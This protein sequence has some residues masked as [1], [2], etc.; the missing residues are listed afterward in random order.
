MDKIMASLNLKFW[1]TLE[2]T[3]ADFSGLTVTPEA[4]DLYGNPSNGSGNGNG[5]G[6]PDG[7]QEAPPVGYEY[8]PPL[9]GQ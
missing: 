5:S 9:A 8:A 1:Y 6:I 2:G 4:T 3:K 7:W